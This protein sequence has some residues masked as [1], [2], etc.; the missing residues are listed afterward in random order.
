MSQPRQYSSHRA[1]ERVLH[2]LQLLDLEIR[3]GSP[4]RYLDVLCELIEQLFEQVGPETLETAA[5]RKQFASSKQR[6]TTRSNLRLV[7]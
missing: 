1:K 6:V 3:L 2:N 4:R 7:Q 5:L